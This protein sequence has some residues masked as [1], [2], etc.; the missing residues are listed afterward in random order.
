MG[1]QDLPHYKQ[2]QQLLFDADMDA[3]SLKQW[4]YRFLEQE[5]LSDAMMFFQKANEGQGLK[6]IR[7][8]AI[9]QGDVFLYKRTID[10]MG[11]PPS[12]QEWK[13]LGERA[14]ELGKLQ[15]AREAYRQAGDRKA[16]DIID[17]MITPQQETNPEQ[18]PTDPETPIV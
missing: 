5:W 18:P 10:A 17:H 6:L 7:N 3:K 16:M 8:K 1:K 2:K 9:D 13:Q 15:F 11:T 12:S 4:G 14:K